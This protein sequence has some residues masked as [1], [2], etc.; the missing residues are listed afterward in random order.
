MDKVVRSI[1]WVQLQ[2]LHRLIKQI[3]KEK[4]SK[5]ARDLQFFCLNTLYFDN[6]N[7]LKCFYPL[8]FT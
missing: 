2:S 4:S 6:T 1:D 7:L 5:L 8:I 3:F